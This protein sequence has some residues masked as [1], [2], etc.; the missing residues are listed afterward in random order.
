M[1]VCRR[2]IPCLSRCLARPFSN[3]SCHSA[4][5]R[6]SATSVTVSRCSVVSA[7][8]KAHVRCHDAIAIAEHR[9]NSE[10]HH[11]VG[12]E[13]ER[14]GRHIEQ[15]LAAHTDGA[16]KG[17]RARVM[18]GVSMAHGS[19]HRSEVV[20]KAIPQNR[21]GEHHLHLSG[22]YVRAVQSGQVSITAV[23][24]KHSRPLGQ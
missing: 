20:C 19:E 8:L 16:P 1:G 22:C 12:S 24:A 15:S 14:T 7:R 13:L 21:V 23:Y 4:E 5:S 6:V 2:S 10:A 3:S 9:S 18:K 17:C 11:A